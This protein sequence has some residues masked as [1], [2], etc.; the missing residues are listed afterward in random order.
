MIKAKERYKWHRNTAKKRNISFEFA[1]EEWYNWWLSNGV[2]KNNPTQ[3]TNGKTLCM[4][5]YGDIGPYNLKNVYCATNS[6]N[7]MD[8]R[9]GGSNNKNIQTP[10][11]IFISRK[12]A[13]EYYQVDPSAITYRM[14]KDSTNWFYL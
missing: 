4:C 13:A 8:A 14:H 10:A 6:Q 9:G 12:A 7:T 1:F 11:G 2:D 3:P 5:R